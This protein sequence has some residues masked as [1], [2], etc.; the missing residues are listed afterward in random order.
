MGQRL[1]VV[2]P[3]LNE[4]ENIGTLL[5]GLADVDDIIV[6]DGGSTDGTA[7]LLASSGVRTIT[8]SK[9]RAMQMNAGAAVSKGDILLFLHADTQMP[10]SFL[11]DLAE[12]DASNRPWGRFDVRFDSVT[13]TL[14]LIAFMMNWRSRLTGIC[15]GDQAIFMR[16][17]AFDSVGGFADLPL[18]ED[19]E[20]SR[21]LRLLNRPY[22]IVEPVTTSSRRW[23]SGG[24]WRTILLMWSLRLRYFFGV[25]PETLAKRYYP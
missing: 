4:A 6:V 22:C 14:S 15:T 5:D 21:R 3:V 1:S 13:P 19:I 12:F 10:S 18:M 24:V 9:G 25:S 17:E 2:I 23:R 7:D 16:R 8:A 11:S 20:I